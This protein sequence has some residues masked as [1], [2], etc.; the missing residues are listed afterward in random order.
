MSSLPDGEG[1]PAHEG[2]AVGGL[3]IGLYAKTNM[4]VTCALW[5]QSGDGWFRNG[6]HLPEPL[7]EKNGEMLV[8]PRAGHGA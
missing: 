6:T 7:G 5:L 1:L 2:V 3:G 8:L 4:S